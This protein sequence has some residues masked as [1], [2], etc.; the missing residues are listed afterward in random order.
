M[1]DETS[2][3]E[4]NL[5]KQKRNRQSC[6]LKLP[7]GK[8]MPS[9]TAFLNASNQQVSSILSMVSHH[10]QIGAI[11]CALRITRSRT[12]LATVTVTNA[13]LHMVMDLSPS[14]HSPVPHY[15]SKTPYVRRWRR[16]GVMPYAASGAHSCRQGRIVVS[17]PRIWMFLVTKQLLVG[18]SLLPSS[19][20]T[21][22][23]RTDC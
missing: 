6:H 2:N 18:K 17:A 1:R 5:C 22:P 3:K 15:R 19:G 14:R 13:S 11:I 20:V 10:E 9:H 21:P 8:A 23:S 7:I 16:R 4:L 12:L